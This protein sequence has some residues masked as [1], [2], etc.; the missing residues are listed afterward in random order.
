MT[1]VQAEQQSDTDSTPATEYGRLGQVRT[2]HCLRKHRVR[3]LHVAYFTLQR[4]T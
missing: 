1:E 4:S 2:A 3:H